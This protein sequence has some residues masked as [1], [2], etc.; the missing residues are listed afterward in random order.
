[1]KKITCRLCGNEY[2]QITNTHLSSKHGLSVEEYKSRFPKASLGEM[3]EEERERQS[4]SGKKAMNRPEVKDKL[5]GKLTP[6]QPKFWVEKKGLSEEK[7]QKRAKQNQSEAHKNR[8]SESY[9]SIWKSGFWEKKGLSEE[10]AKKKVS[11]IQSRNSEKASKFEGKSHTAE[12]KRKI[13]S[14]MSSVIEGNKSEWV[15]HFNSDGFGS[16]LEREI[17]DWVEKS[18]TNIQRNY[19]LETGDVVDIIDGDKVIEVYGDFWH[20]HPD[21]FE[22]DER[23]P[24]LEERASKVREKDHQRKNRIEEAGY[25]IIVIWENDWNEHTKQAKNKIKNHL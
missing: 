16:K 22:E 4:K 5:Q 23:H 8:S 21:M 2:K 14:S 24:V 15:E 19:E 12:S 17:G 1:M 3:T 20:C 9:E 6:S 13:A 10:E 7:A 25:D 11:E 18:I